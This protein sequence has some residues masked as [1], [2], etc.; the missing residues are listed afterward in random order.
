[1]PRLRRVSPGMPGW[2]RRPAGRGFRY[3]DERGHPLGA[4]Q[5][6]RVQDLVIPPAWRDVWICPLP[7]GHLQATGLDVAGRRQY[8][9][10]PHWRELR[11]REKFD[12]VTRAAGRLPDV[13]RRVRD[14][15]A[16]DS[17]PLAR[18][19]ATAVRLLD[20]GYF[21]IGNDCYADANGTFGLTTLQR[22]HVHR[23]GDSLGFRFVGKSGIEH[24]LLIEDPPAIEALQTMRRRHGGERLLAYRDGGEWRDLTSSAVNAYLADLFGGAFT[25]KDFRTWHATVL[26]A[27]ALAG[28]PP[29]GISATARKRAVRAAIAEVAS[30]LGNTPAIARS[31][32]VDPRIVDRYHAG[33]IIALPVD[34]GRT[35]AD[36]RR[37]ARERAVIDLLG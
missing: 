37:S 10:H 27:T 5:I 31:S 18:A 34:D 25:A 15:L 24:R 29:D 35:N 6:A 17:M 9:Y 19:A 32:Y 23:Q 36:E 7:Q 20:L 4:D 8:L 33:E 1:M 12:R 11:D 16:L 22:R 26:C 13:R 21:R 14:D 2:T 3:L 28:A 30:Y